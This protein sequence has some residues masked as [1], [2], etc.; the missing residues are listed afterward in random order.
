[1]GLQPT[2]SKKSSFDRANFLSKLVFWWL[3]KFF[4]E[5]Q[6]KRLKTSDLEVCPKSTASE[7]IGSKLEKEWVKELKKSSKDPKGGGKKPSLGWAIIRAIG[8]NYSFSFILLVFQNIFPFVQTLFMGELVDLIYQMSK[9]GADIQSIKTKIYY[10]GAAVVV[11]QILGSYTNNYYWFYAR[12]GGLETRVA[13]SRLIYHKT[14]KLSQKA[15]GQ[16]TTGQIVNLLSNDVARFDYAAE[17]PFFFIFGPIQVVL[18]LW[19]LWP[20]LGISAVVGFIVLFLFAPFQT[21]MG[22][23]FGKLRTAGAIRTDERIRLM[24]EFIPAMRVIKMYAWEKP[25]AALVDYA[26]KREVAKIRG[27]AY[28]KGVN[29]GAGTVSEKLI[30][31]LILVVFILTGHHLTA[32]TVFVAMALVRQLQYTITFFIPLGISSGAEALIS[33]KRIQKFLELPELEENNSQKSN[34]WKTSEPVI[35]CKNVE[36]RWR[37]DHDPVLSGIDFK[38]TKNQLLTVIGPVGSGKST[39]LTSLLGEV[40]PSKGTMQVSGKMS[41]ACQQAWIFAGTVQENILFGNEFDSIRYKQVIHVAALERDMKILPAGDQTVVGDRGASLSGG[42]RARI[43]L[44]RALY[45][46]ADIYL[47]DDPLSAV[48]APVAKHIFEKSVKSFLK[49]K[50]VVLVT[51]QLQFL[52]QADRILYLK[53]EKQVCFGD[54][55]EFLKLGADF[56]EGI[57]S[58]QPDKHAPAE[59]KVTRTLSKRLSRQSSVASIMTSAS[60]LDDDIVEEFNPHKGHED[61]DEDADANELGVVSKSN[62]LWT[63]TKA[64]IGPLLLPFWFIY[65]NGAQALISFIEYYFSLWTD[66]E[67]R[68]AIALTSGNETQFVPL[69][70]VDNFSV[71]TNIYFFTGLTIAL[72]IWCLTRNI[73]FFAACMKASIKLHDN[74]FKAV[75]RAPISFFDNNPPGIILNRVS[76]DMGMVDD[77]LPA[78]MFDTLFCLSTCAGQIILM[79]V[80][81]GYLAIP[82][83][84]LLIVSYIARAY[85]VN[86]A[87]DVKRLEGVTKT[88]VFSHLSTSVSGL[89]TI[90]AF[91]VEKRFNE[92]FDLF[93]D[94]HSSAYFTWI[95]SSRFFIS[96]V[97]TI[98]NVYSV[99]V[100]VIILVVMDS[101]NGSSIGLVISSSIAL[102]GL[103]QWGMRQLTEVET[104]LTSVER[105]DELSYIKPEA[106]LDSTP[107]NRPSESWPDSGN[108]EFKNVYLRYD[109]SKPPVLDNLN[110]SIKAREKVG[111]IGRTGAGKS[112][113]MTALY[114]M[115]EPEGRIIIDNVDISQ[116]GLHD[117][118]KK[119]S[120]IPQEPIIFTGTVRYNLDPFSLK[121]DAD[122]WEALTQVQLK[123]AVDEMGG[124]DAKI[125]DGGTNLSVGQRQLVCLARAILNNNKILVLDEATANIDPSTDELIQ[126]TI[127]KRFT[128]CTVLTIAHRLHTVMDSDKI[129][130]M[131]AGHVA[132]FGDPASLVKDE[133]GILY[134]MVQATGKESAENLIKIAM[135][136]RLSLKGFEDS[137][138]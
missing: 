91:G 124:L 3:T 7:W 59:K 18:Y 135:K 133:S 36:L 62:S 94:E 81:N 117:L 93:Q 11:S 97:Y 38:I 102:A 52:K 68:R 33:I 84:L 73:A 40:K 121:T 123:R 46:K 15:L 34:N 76:R 90:R 120:I 53:N 134:S 28:L 118:R 9:A 86:I 56:I 80:V 41:Y 129:L 54:Y 115:T 27:A 39:L 19:I 63:Y 105:I 70:F 100:M 119:I 99:L 21:F 10:Y 14:L 82:S 111:I 109:L 98:S 136:R 2:I 96:L 16:T 87:R 57:A 1:M 71:M 103:I 4:I 78:T 35:E 74:L 6:N 128:N 69:N 13:C 25:F 95:A 83:L 12:R 5:S 64:G 61:D 58:S 29:L 101:L 110:F 131:D 50:I 55:T 114:R 17:F 60:I 26:R 75:V 30:M 44:A 24:N 130:V 47:L 32:K 104:M 108:I 77:F 66:S 132:Q 107:A 79:A 49:D 67:Q 122:L 126:Q 112:S 48:D 116:I 137:Q 138:E 45:A 22:K 127:R 72:T 8:P 43:N 42:Q 31:F 92:N 65:I 125:T 89:T 37:D 51:H 20:Q 23:A 85:Y 106:E 88:P 113:I